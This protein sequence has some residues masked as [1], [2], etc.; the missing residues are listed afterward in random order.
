MT[1]GS[2]LNLRTAAKLTDLN[3]YQLATADRLYN[4]LVLTTT[5]ATVY[6]LGSHALARDRLA[7]ETGF[8]LRDNQWQIEVQGWF[9]TGLAKLQA[10]V[11]EYATNVVDLGP[12][13]SIIEPILQPTPSTTH[14]TTCALRSVYGIRRL[15]ILLVSRSHDRR[16]RRLNID[17]AIVDHRAHHRVH[18]AAEAEER[19]P[20]TRL[21]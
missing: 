6:H 8:S 20:Q 2:Q 4:A 17:P 19:K 12:Y 5:Y 9:E 11:V 15:S 3:S 14:S 7:D 21:S 13:R 18:E 1:L 10:Y 16:L